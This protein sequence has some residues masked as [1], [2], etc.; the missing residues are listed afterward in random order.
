MDGIQIGGGKQ[1]IQDITG[2]QK[3]DCTGPYAFT[4]RASI[5]ATNQPESISYGQYNGTDRGH[6][7]SIVD[8]GAVI[9]LGLRNKAP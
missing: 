3:Y 7:G 1:R 8:E 2:R 9:M 5:P 4:S 6:V